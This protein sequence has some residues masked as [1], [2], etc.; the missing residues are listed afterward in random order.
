MLMITGQLQV[1]LTIILEQDGTTIC[2][3]DELGTG[4]MEQ[5]IIYGLTPGI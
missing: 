5:T 4:T 1:L 2:A 3:M